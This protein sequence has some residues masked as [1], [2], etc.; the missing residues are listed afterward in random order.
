MSR[1]ASLAK[2][3][4]ERKMDFSGRPRVHPWGP[5]YEGPTGVS[6]VLVPL[7][8][9]YHFDTPKFLGRRCQ[10]VGPHSGPIDG[11]MI[12]WQPTQASDHQRKGRSFGGKLAH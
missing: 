3:G 9:V 11:S 8:G 10:E 1:E 12:M 6:N 5:G 4:Q 7:M 2:A